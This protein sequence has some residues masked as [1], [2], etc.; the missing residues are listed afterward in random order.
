L[1]SSSTSPVF[2]SHSVAA[3]SAAIAEPTSKTGHSSPSQPVALVASSAYSVAF[4]D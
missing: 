2:E 3:T 1:A 4:T